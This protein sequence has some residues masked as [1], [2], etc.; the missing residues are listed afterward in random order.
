MK[1]VLH[2]F[3]IVDAAFETIGSVIVDDEKITDV[4]SRED[5]LRDESRLGRH[6]NNAGLVVNGNGKFILTCGFVDM[7]AHFRSPGFPKKETIESGCL[8]AA[9]GGWTTVVC[10]ANTKPVIDNAEAAF[11]IKKTSDSLGLIDLYPVLS[12]TKKMQGKRLVDFL[13]TPPNTQAG[14]YPYSPLLLSE[15]GKDVENEELFLQ[16]MKKAAYLDIPVSCH[17][18]IQNEVYAVRRAVRLGKKADCKL[19]IA[20]ISTKAAAEVVRQNKK[21][22]RLTAEATPHH[23]ALNVKDG[24]K[25][26]IENFGKVAPPLR[27][28]KD[29]MAIIE[30]LADC[31]ID[32][33]ATDHAPHTQSDKMKGDPGFSGLETAFSVCNTILVKENN[34]SLNRLLSLLNAAPASILGLNDRAHIAAGYRADLVVLD[35][36]KKYVCRAEDLKSRGKNSPFDKKELTGKVVMTIRGGN[37]VYSLF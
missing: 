18:D 2:D 32:A 10:M 22:F 5:F 36:E 8:A 17:C 34:F 16:A 9:A 25:L 6:L 12:L 31:T 13:N 37:I 7:H 11:K 4:I 23:I 14:V 1:L 19:H 26:G 3:K 15:D 21:H 35:S 28:E 33:I 29:R 27:S 30:A 20:H 24:Q